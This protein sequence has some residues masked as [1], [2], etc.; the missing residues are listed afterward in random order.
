[1]KLINECNKFNMEMLIDERLANESMT[2][3]DI[4]YENQNIIEIQRINPTT[5][6]GATKPLF[7]KVWP[8]LAHINDPEDDIMYSSYLGNGS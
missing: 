5:I 4:Q 3:H 8:E 2:L 6:I 7:N 1:M